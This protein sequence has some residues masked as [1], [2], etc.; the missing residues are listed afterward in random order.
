MRK[1]LWITIGFGAAMGWCAYISAEIALPVWILLGSLALVALGGGFW[2][3]WLRRPAAV[4]IG[5]LFG[6]SWF[7]FYQHNY[8]AP[9][10]AQNG[11]EAQVTVTAGDYGYDTDRGT[12]VNGYVLLN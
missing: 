1:L 3:E 6:L 9:A 12:G 5:I 8:L 10:Q 7:S 11:I 4:L 2:W